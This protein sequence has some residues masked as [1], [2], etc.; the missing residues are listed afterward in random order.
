M[1]VEQQLEQEVPAGVQIETEEEVKGPPAVQIEMEDAV[2][3]P[4][5][6]AVAEFALNEWLCG[7]SGRSGAVD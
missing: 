1:A 3:A 5:T 6:S 2:E 4:A 7:L